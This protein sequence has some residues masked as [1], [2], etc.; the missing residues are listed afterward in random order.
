MKNRKTVEE[1]AQSAANRFLK[2]QDIQSEEG[3]C[4][5]VTDDYPDDYPDGWVCFDCKKRSLEII[6]SNTLIRYH[7]NTVESC[8]LIVREH[9]Q[10]ENPLAGESGD[11][12]VVSCCAK[13]LSD[14][15]DFKYK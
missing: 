5:H 7:R 1:L 3:G 12:K 9:L 14:L 2:I 4:S 13:T 10:H 15:A 11:H 8:R 6:I